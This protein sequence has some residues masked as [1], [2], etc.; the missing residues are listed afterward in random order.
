MI[1]LRLCAIHVL[2]GFS[3][4]SL[5]KDLQVLCARYLQ[6][7]IILDLVMLSVYWVKLNDNKPP[8]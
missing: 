6:Y 2:A 5:T 7:H 8:T 4:H 3:V 1:S